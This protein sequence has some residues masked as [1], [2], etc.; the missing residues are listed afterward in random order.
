[1]VVVVVVVVVLWYDISR[2]GGGG[3]GCN[4]GGCGCCS[5]C[6]FLWLIHVGTP[7]N[8]MYSI[9]NDYFTYVYCQQPTVNL[10]SDETHIH[11][12]K[13][14]KSIHYNHL[15]QYEVNIFFFIMKTTITN[16][17]LETKLLIP[18][19][20]WRERKH[21]K[22]QMHVRSSL[23]PLP[24]ISEWIINSERQERKH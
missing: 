21:N 6:V 16:T 18:H 7:N 13:K 17:V 5:H 14:K 19:S 2:G 10:T 3:G 1:M 23:G 24:S 9:N 4:G 8:F 20:Q 11:T 15:L 12:H 22:Q